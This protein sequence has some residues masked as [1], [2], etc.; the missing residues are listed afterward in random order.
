M[1]MDFSEIVFVPLPLTQ[2]QSKFYF[3]HLLP[4]G[5]YFYGYGLQR[6]RNDCSYTL[7]TIYIISLGIF[8]IL[9]V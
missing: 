7:I 5:Y 8:W 6:N 4:P 9:N 2:F 3:T 1:V